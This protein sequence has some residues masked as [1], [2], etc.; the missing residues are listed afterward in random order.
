MSVCELL[1]MMTVPMEAKE[2]VE[3]LVVMSCF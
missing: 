2:G 3:A 1:F